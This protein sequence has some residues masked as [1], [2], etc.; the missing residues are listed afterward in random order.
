MKYKNPAN[1]KII[2]KS[3]I[4]Q[5]QPNLV[6]SWHSQHQCSEEHM[7]HQMSSP[8]YFEKKYGSYKPIT[9]RYF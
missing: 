7:R 6:L 9:E 3:E 5:I 8:I 4:P 1:I 2:F